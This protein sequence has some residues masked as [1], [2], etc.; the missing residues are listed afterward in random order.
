MNPELVLMH[1]SKLTALIAGPAV[2]N[3]LSKFTVPAKGEEAGA[4]ISVLGTVL[5]E[6]L[7][8]MD[9]PDVQAAFKAVIAEAVVV[10]PSAGDQPPKEVELG[11]VWKSHFIGKAGSLVRFLKWACQAQYGDFFSAMPGLL[12][13]GLKERFASLA[14]SVATKRTEASQTT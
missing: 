13:G 5:G 4:V 2:Q 12:A 3:A 8:H 10:Y 11:A 6:A 7:K 9:H 1:G 14:S